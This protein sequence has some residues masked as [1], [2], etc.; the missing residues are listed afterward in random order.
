[1][2]SKTSLVYK[3][4]MY[5]IEKIN[6]DSQPDSA[7]TSNKQQGNGN[8]VSKTRNRRMKKPAEPSIPELD[9]EKK[10]FMESL[11]LKH[12]KS[13]TKSR[14]SSRIKINKGR[15]H[16]KRCICCS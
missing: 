9:E 10:L 14:R 8:T 4:E 7:K 11:G 2:G 3:A 5:K 13:I 16:C 15:N 1:M 6:V 12:V